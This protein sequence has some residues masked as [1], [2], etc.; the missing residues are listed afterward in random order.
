MASK[1]QIITAMFNDEV[2]K[3]TSNLDNWTSFLR[4]ASNNFKYNFVEQI[5]IY[6][7]RP[8]ATAC[9]EIGFWNDKMHRWVN[10]GATGIA[11]FDYSGSYFLSAGFGGAF[12]ADDQRCVLADVC[13]DG[14]IVHGNVFAD[15]C[16]GNQIALQQA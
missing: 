10:R 11:L 13:I 5:L 3:V 1:L 6:S 16:C 4:T 8:D 12:Y 2:G 15:V 14:S 7:Q 9:A